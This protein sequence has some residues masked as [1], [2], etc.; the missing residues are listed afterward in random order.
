MRATASRNIV[1]FIQ[2]DAETLV[3]RRVTND[4]YRRIVKVAETSDIMAEAFAEVV[5]A[6]LE[7]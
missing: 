4:E 7:A 1:R 2:A 6:A 3:G 5:A